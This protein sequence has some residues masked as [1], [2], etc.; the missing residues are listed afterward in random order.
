MQSS[1]RPSGRTPRAPGT[2]TFDRWEMRI[3]KRLI[4]LH[5]PSDVTWA[6]GVV[7]GRETTLRCD[8]NQATAPIVVD[9]SLFSSTSV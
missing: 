4:D 6:P 9:S 7:V 1:K 3:H 5:S 2:N 8:R